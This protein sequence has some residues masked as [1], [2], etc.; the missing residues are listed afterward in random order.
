MPLQEVHSDGLF[1][2]LGE[3][4]LA[5]TLDHTGL[6]D[7]SVTDYDHLD[8]H[9]HILLQHGGDVWLVLSVPLCLGSFNDVTRTQTQAESVK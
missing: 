4:A 9:F 6:A 7:S 1:V 3:D 5:V 8:G 2:V